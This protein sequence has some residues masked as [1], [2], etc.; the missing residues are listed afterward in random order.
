[1]RVN[2]SAVAGL[3]TVMAC[4]GWQLQSATPSPGAV[5]GTGAQSQLPLQP[6][7][8]R[9]EA[10]WPAFEGWGPDKRDGTNLI[11]IGYNNR[12]TNHEIDIPIG[13]DNHIDPGGPDHGQ[14]THFL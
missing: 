14:P 2:R 10:I 8:V 4:A 9:G 3:A 7:G 12:N 13:P 1:M 11:L 5:P 6:P